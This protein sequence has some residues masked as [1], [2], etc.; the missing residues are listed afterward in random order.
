MILKGLPIGPKSKGVAMTNVS[1]FFSNQK[2]H[3]KFIACFFTLL[4]GILLVFSQAVS[5][6]WSQEAGQEEAEVVDSDDLEGRSGALEVFE[7]NH[8][9]AT[10][11]VVRE[12]KF[13]GSAINKKIYFNHHYMGKIGNARYAVYLVPPGEYLLGVLE[14][15]DKRSITLAVDKGNIYYARLKIK[16]GIAKARGEFTHISE[17]DAKAL[18]PELKKVKDKNVEEYPAE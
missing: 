9:F 2:V 15:K 5:S 10:I 11:Y 8:D 7:P 14:N 1:K 3:K 6:S 13:K 12:K 18:I 16:M 4:L 17:Q